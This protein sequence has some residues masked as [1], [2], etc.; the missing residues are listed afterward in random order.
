M[1]IN[2]DFF[3]QNHRKSQCQFAPRESAQFFQFILCCNDS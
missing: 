2:K 3:T 1:D